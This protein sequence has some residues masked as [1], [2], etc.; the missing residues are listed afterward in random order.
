MRDTKRSGLRHVATACLF[1][2]LTMLWAPA[3]FSQTM[4][5]GDIVG[6]VTDAS[7]AV[8]PGA[9]VTIHFADTN[10][11]HSAVTNSTGQYR[12]SL[13]QPG[14]YTVT[15]EAT[16]LEIQYRKIHAAGGP[17]KRYQSQIGGARHAASGRGAGHSRNPADGK[18]Q[19]GDPASTPRR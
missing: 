15:A 19:P 14:E 10:E 16:G 2:A 1:A 3:A 9:K 6:T 8:V 5:T 11:S 18:C 12:F 7:S 4:T 17:G 13:L